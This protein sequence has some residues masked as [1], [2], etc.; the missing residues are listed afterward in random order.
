MSRL[1]PT[2]PELQ[3][4][5]KE[6]E[7]EI[8]ILHEQATLDFLTG[9]YNQ[10]GF[11][12]GMEMQFI[13]KPDVQWTGEER[14]ERRRSHI[15]GTLVLLDLTGFKGVN[16]AISRA[17]GDELL[18]LVAS[19]IR[20]QVR[21][22]TDVVGRYGGDEFTLFFRGRNKLFVDERME[23]IRRRIKDI[24]LGMSVEEIEEKLHRDFL[25]DFHYVSTWVDRKVD[26]KKLLQHMNDTLKHTSRNSSGV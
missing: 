3:R 7:E 26:F 23:V 9:I 13:D 16:D 14:R 20:E 6:L 2:V 11:F 4:K 18:I 8:E 21:D 5:I 19:T 15:S 22:I 24:T 17:S 12:Q 1:P 10:R 25:V